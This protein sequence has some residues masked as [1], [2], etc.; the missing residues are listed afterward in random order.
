MNTW[1]IIAIAL[2]LVLAG[3]AVVYGLATPDAPIA[4]APAQTGCGQCSGQCS[5]SGG[6][7]SPGCGATAGQGCGCSK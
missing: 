4:K 1:T 3:G 2:V 5:G 6:C 7:G